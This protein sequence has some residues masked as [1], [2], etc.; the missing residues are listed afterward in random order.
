MS[1][2]LIVN[3]AALS[4]PLPSSKSD[5]GP[6]LHDP[7]D[8]VVITETQTTLTQALEENHQYPL[9]AVA[10]TSEFP[11]EAG[12][13]VFAFGYEN[14]VGPVPYL[15]VSGTSHL[16]LNPSS[17]ISSAVALGATVNLA[18]RMSDDQVPHGDGDFWLTP[19]PAGRAACESNIDDIAAAAR[20]V[21]MT[22]QYP[23]DIGLAGAGLPTH[24]VDR[25]SDIVAVFSSDDTDDEVATAR[26]S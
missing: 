15:G 20:A 1:V 21:T 4:T 3:P 9:V 24:G 7:T 10:D 25:I 19:S 8:S 13:L 2:T 5:D 17:T 14:Q 6:Y 18:A 23:G 26:E 16:I 11:D 12:Y 22:V